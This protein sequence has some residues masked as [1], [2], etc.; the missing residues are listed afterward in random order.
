MAGPLR[1]AVEEK[2]REL[3]IKLNEAGE[4]ANWKTL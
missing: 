1:E 2:G 3:R 4:V